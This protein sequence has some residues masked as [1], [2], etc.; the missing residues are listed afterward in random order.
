MRNLVSLLVISQEFE[1]DQVIIPHFFLTKNIAQMKRPFIFRTI[2]LRFQRSRHLVFAQNRVRH[3]DR[4][5]R[6][7]EHRTTMSDLLGASP[8]QT[9]FYQSHIVPR[10][11][12]TKRVRWHT[13]VMLQFKKLLQIK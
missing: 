4:L 2:S 7:V 12:L 11:F 13:R 6:F 8:A 5:T 9:L 3:D 10:V 1:L